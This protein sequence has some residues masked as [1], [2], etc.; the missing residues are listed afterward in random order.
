VYRG[1]SVTPG[2]P[3]D[4]RIFPPHVTKCLRFF[5]V[6]SYTEDTEV[7]GFHEGPDRPGLLDYRYKGAV[8]EHTPSFSQDWNPSPHKAQSRVEAKRSKRKQLALIIGAS[9]VGVALLSVLITAGIWWALGP[10]SHK[11]TN[12]PATSQA[13]Q[14]AEATDNTPKT[15]KSNTQNIEFTYPGTWRVRENTDKTQVMITSPQVTYQKAGVST[16]GVFT[17][18]LRTGIVPQIMQNTLQNIVAIQKSEVIAYANPTD[19]QRAYTN[20]SFGG[21]A[22]KMSLLMVTGGSEFAPGESF[23]SGLDMQGAFYLVAGG[24]GSDPNDSLT[25]DGLP[26]SSFTGT[27]VYREAVGIIES[28]RVY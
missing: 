28:I 19:Q 21:K 25:F 16:Q 18:K 11:P 23:A 17:L 3:E 1:G 2:T 8:V 5:A 9:V 27:A 10:R 6:W 7:W 24:Y 4:T 14:K 20:L 13:T 15:F 12:T 26:I 22:D